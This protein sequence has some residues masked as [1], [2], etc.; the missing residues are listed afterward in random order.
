MKRFKRLYI[1]ITNICN[2]SCSFCPET[3]RKKSYMTIESF[4]K[5]LDRFKGL[6]DY[7]YL[8]VK[9]EPLLHP[10]IDRILEISGEKGFKVNITTNGHNIADKKDILLKSMSLR[11]ISFSLQS[12]DE[13]KDIKKVNSYL[14]DILDFVKEANK[15]NLIVELRLWNLNDKLDDISKNLN[16]YILR[17]IEKELDLKYKLELSVSKEKG[18]KVKDNLY[19]SQ[20]YLFEW[21]DINRKIISTTG[22]CYGLRNQIA[23]LVDG[24][25]VPC[26]LDSDGIINL[27][28]IFE[29]N[30]IEILESNKVKK[31]YNGFSNRK[32]VE[33]L[34][35]RCGYRTRFDK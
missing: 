19:L 14:K 21:P 24:T 35:Q 13:I 28:N 1:E 8:H 6:T 27:G 17:F 32:V 16:P 10:D 12:I 20:S 3:K 9:G 33:P 15:I 29:N 2:L 26:C 18:D 11:Q 4:E 34:C 7:I 22:F 5:V 23:V 25:I 31:I 30:I